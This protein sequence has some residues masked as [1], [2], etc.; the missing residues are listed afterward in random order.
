MGTKS[1]PKT[2]ALLGLF[3]DSA[4]LPVGLFCAVSDPVFF[5][6]CWPYSA[7]PA[8]SWQGWIPISIDETT[9]AATVVSED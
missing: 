7:V 9:G 2:G 5:Y 8:R 6:V 3:P 1:S 4:D